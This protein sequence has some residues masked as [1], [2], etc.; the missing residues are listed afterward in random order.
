[1]NYPMTE[2]LAQFNE[3]SFS[4]IDFSKAEYVNTREKVQV[5]CRVHGDFE[6]APHRIRQRIQERKNVCPKC[7][8]ITRS[9]KATGSL[10]DFIQKSKE[11][12]GNTY[13]YDNA[14]Y[15]NANTKVAV[16]CPAHGDFL[17]VPGNH[18]RGSKCPECDK[19]LAKERGVASRLTREEFIRQAVEIHGDKYDYSQVELQGNKVPVKVWCK[20]HEE[21]FYPT[22]NNH[23]SNKAGCGKCGIEKAHSP[24]KKTHHDISEE[25]K[26]GIIAGTIDIT[27]LRYSKGKLVIDVKK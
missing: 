9:S 11:K 19:L 18:Y 3:E 12:H 23:I 7:N 20:A 1:M 15:V 17:V 2:F 21:F 24:F 6:V 27:A 16:T 8:V 10:K 14:V 22:P 13:V 25:I 5:S 4:N 26:Q